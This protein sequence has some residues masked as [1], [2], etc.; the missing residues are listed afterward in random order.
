MNPQHPTTEAGQAPLLRSQRVRE[1]TQDLHKS[2][3]DTVGEWAPTDTLPGFT[4]FVQM[5]YLFQSEIQALYHDPEL[6]KLFADLPERCR[7]KAAE[8]DLADLGAQVPAAVPGALQA[9]SKAQALAW[10]RVS[11]GSKLGAA[12]LFKQAVALGFSETHGA[13]HLAEPEGGRMRGWK[14]FNAIFDNLPLSAEEEAEVDQ[15]SRDAFARLEL[16]L[17][18]VGK[19]AT[20]PQP[21]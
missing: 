21:A 7:V 11:E 10:I 9:P 4:R 20:S 6:V 13:R 17:R 16:L 14:A 2:L 15:A 18:T 8:A 19:R 1:L 5:Q 3:E 12:I